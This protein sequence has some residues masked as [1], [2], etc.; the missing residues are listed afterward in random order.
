MAGVGPGAQA[1]PRRDGVRHEPFRSHDRHQDPASNHRPRAYPFPERLR[2]R[3][4][5]QNPSFRPRPYRVIIANQWEGTPCVTGRQTRDARKGRGGS[6]DFS[7]CRSQL[8]TSAA[9]CKKSLC[10]MYEFPRPP[11]YI[12]GLVSEFIPVAVMKYSPE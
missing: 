9:G 7:F 3:G 2:S 1:A 5:R 4:C 10:E 8:E 6:H 11:G 12:C